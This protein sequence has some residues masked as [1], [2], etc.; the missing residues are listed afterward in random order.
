MLFALISFIL[1]PVT[2]FRHRARYREYEK[3]R[4]GQ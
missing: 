2:W 4:K 1:H 3:E